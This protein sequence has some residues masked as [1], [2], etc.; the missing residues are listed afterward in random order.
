MNRRDFVSMLGAFAAV[1]RSGGRSVGPWNGTYRLPAL[2]PSRLVE[3]WSWAMGQPVHLMLFHESEAAGLEAA[4]K[5]LEE[6]RRVELRLS[7]FDDASDLSELNRHAGKAPMKVDRDLLEVLT[8][9][10]RARQVTSAAFDIAVEP[11]MRV[12]GFRDP[13]KAPPGAIELRE[14]EKAVRASVVRIDGTRVTLS[15]AVT[16]LDL[17]GIGVGYGLD[18]AANVLR[19]CGVERAF[20][21]VSGDCIALGAPPGEEGWL[22]DLADP[23]GSG[24]SRPA[25]FLRDRALTTSANTM[26]VVRYG[27]VVRGHVMDPATGYPA[28]RMVQVSVRAKRGIDADVLSTAML[29][30]GRPF[31]GVE[32][33]WGDRPTAG[34]G[35]GEQGR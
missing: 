26:S 20:L 21:D 35:N 34:T 18:R 2:S 15:S 7:R 25:G 8:A 13:R 4:A 16:Q 10:A 33:W 5:A 3:R 14:A 32:K 1:G 17:G 29:V 27:A 31:E 28:D 11:L 6:L 22:V 12:W 9:A 19:T 24:P 23:N 30:A